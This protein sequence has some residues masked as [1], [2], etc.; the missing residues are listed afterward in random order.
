ML[1]TKDLDN[2]VF[3]YIYTWGETL[4]TISWA[5]RD[6][7]HRTIMATTCK[8]V[9][10]RDMFF[11]LASVIDWRVVTSAKQRQVDIDNVRENAKRVTHDYSIGDQVYVEMTGIYLRLGYSKH[12]PCKI[13]EVFT[14]GIVRFQCEQIN[15]RT[16]V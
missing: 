5:I 4:S 15:E 2:K 16:L 11:N 3:D 13:T 14:N 8:A 10:G 7:Y 9:F 12:G 1:V 6:S